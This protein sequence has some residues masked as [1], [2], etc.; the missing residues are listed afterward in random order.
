[1]NICT[2]GAVKDS[3]EKIW[4]PILNTNLI[5]KCN[6]LGVLDDYIL[7]PSPEIIKSKWILKVIDAKDYLFA[8]SKHNNIVWKIAKSSNEILRIDYGFNEIKGIIDIVPCGKYAVI[9]T[10]SS[11]FP[12]LLFDLYSSKTEVLSA[13][14]KIQDVDTGFIRGVCHEDCVYTA[15]RHL[16]NVQLCKIDVENRYLSFLSINVKMINAIEKENDCWWIFAL[17]TDGKTVLQKHN[18]DFS[19]CIQEFVLDDIEEIQET[20]LMYYFR[21]E[22]CLNKVFFIPAVAKK[23]FI[24]DVSKREGRYLCYPSEMKHQKRMYSFIEEQRI[25][26]IIYLFPH[27]FQQIMIINLETEEIEVL[28]VAFDNTN[29]FSILK[30]LVH[31][32]EIFRENDPLS[33]KEFL[34]GI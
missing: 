30:L 34:I 31:N 19:K 18:M 5:L 2:W 33:I 4:L 23:I 28:D 3:N 11:Q 9:L 6:D 21:I 15:T 1:M 16:N 14:G 7:L 17:N 10:V 29:S 12:I 24:Y 32:T 27:G 22:V 13:K 26:N 8:F 20:G 25:D